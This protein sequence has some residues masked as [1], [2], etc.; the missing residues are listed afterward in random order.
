MVKK[1][2]A[3]ASVA[4]DAEPAV[5]WARLTDPEL[6]SQAFFGATVDTDWRPGSTIT[7]S[8]EWQ[9]RPFQ[10]TGEIVTVEPARVLRF[11]H[12]SPL[13][14]QPDVPENY[15]TVT[16]ELTP[17]EGGTDLTVHQTN[18]ASEEEREHSAANWSS[19][20]NTVKQVSEG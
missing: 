1:L 10:D 18:A 19:V 12:F 7:F 17:W 6:I 15:H 4:I 13:T 2:T 5:V 16:F 11:T 20:L 14:G 9:G 3:S 8:G